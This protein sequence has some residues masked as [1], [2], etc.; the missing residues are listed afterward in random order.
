MG[1]GDEIMATAF[2]KIE[3]KKYPERQVVVGDAKA[4]TAKYSKIYYNNPNISDPRKLDQ[5]K[6]VH[7]VD[8]NNSNRPYIDWT[9]SKSG[10]LCWNINH[11]AIPGELYFDKQE[12]N[13][14]ENVIKDAK[15][16]W[17]TYN[18]I[19]N[20]GIIFI[21]TSRIIKKN[22]MPK[23]IYN[24]NW[25]P[26]RWEKT[27]DILKKSYLIVNS[28]HT[29]SFKHDNIFSYG[30]EFRVACAIMKYCDIYLGPEGGFAHAAAALSKPAVVIFGGW[31]TPKVTGYEFHEN[32]YVDIEGS[33]CGIRDRECDHCKKCMDL[34][35]VDNVVNAVEK[36]INKKINY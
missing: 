16:F 10:K 33:P 29:K 26:E 20:K 35:T 21:E 7:F 17:K 31:I 12:I 2:A 28:T 13:E 18:S 36:N 1:Y 5:N 27:I 24:R 34:I 15:K 30:C 4:R 25:S 8:H 3:K 22:F 14:A 9:K 6:I 19:K 23:Q 11:R 32:L